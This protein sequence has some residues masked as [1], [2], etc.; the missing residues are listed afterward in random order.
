MLNK[1]KCVDHLVTK[2]F[3]ESNLALALSTCCVRIF[4]PFEMSHYTSLTFD[5]STKGLDVAHLNSAH[6]GF[7]EETVFFSW[8]LLSREV[9][10]PKMGGAEITQV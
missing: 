7:S 4:I 6:V 2:I 10:A 5:S 9:I 1:H 3:L 8:L